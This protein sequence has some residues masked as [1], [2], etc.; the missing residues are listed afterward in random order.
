MES[1]KTGQL[2]ARSLTTNLAPEPQNH[3]LVFVSGITARSGTN[4]L[5]RL[6]I[7]HPDCCRPKGHWELPLFEVADKFMEFYELFLRTRNQ[8]R[9]DYPFEQFA[10][11][12][13]KG[14][15]HLLS[16]KVAEPNRE[17]RYL[18]LKNPATKGIEH[19]KKF[20][21]SGKLIFLVR[22]GR[23]NVNS[24]LA[25]EGFR[26]NTWKRLRKNVW[27]NPNR[28]RYFLFHTRQWASSARRILDY[29]AH[30]DA[31]YLIVKY[32][33]LYQQPRDSIKHIAEYI[34]LP[35][36]AQWLDEIEKTPIKGSGF[37]REVARSVTE[38]AGSTNWEQELP[39]SDEFKPVGRWRNSWSAMDRLLFYKLAGRELEDLGYN[40]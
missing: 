14:F 2:L 4:F 8:G 13:G 26:K 25:A 35:V 6:L 38:V 15:F 39:K 7:T 36:T 34:G 29:L 5:T 11:S 32:E 1:V 24:L 20:F 27:W 9:L 10:A 37:Y 40:R 3:I 28:L 31:D 19:F 22:D 21:P 17:A 33:D 18:L 12:F 16:E 23:D 30:P